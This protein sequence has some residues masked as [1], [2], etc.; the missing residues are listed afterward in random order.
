[1]YAGLPVVLTFLVDPMWDSPRKKGQ[2][3]WAI[4][5]NASTPLDR[6]S[7]ERGV[8]ELCTVKGHF[9]EKLAAFAD[10]LDIYRN[11]ADKT[12]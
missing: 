7:A 6:L 8:A 9:D 11:A 4:T 10:A 2:A 5:A 1:M 3:V 12:P